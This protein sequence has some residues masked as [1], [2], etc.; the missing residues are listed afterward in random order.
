MEPL[1][2]AVS[3]FYVGK[4]KINF[5]SLVVTT[6]TFT[7]S[8]MFSYMNTLHSEKATKNVNHIEVFLDQNTQQSL[9][10]INVQE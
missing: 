5:H 1:F 9:C 6:G 10:L 2:K 4:L 8:E 3:L 7:C